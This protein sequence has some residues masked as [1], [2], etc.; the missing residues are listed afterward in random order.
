MVE[1]APSVC[2][3]RGVRPSSLL[4]PSS[5]T[6]HFA[7]PWAVRSSVPPN[8]EGRTLA[9]STLHP[10]DIEKIKEVVATAV[11]SLAPTAKVLDVEEKVIHKLIYRN[12]NQ[13]RSMEHFKRIKALS[14]V[15]ASTKDFPSGLTLA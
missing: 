4:L 10:A 9:S 15:S 2:R 12:R 1:L 8:W 3:M 6:I 11:D 13:H 7:A 14:K 5:K